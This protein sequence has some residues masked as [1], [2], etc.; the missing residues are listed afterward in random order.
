MAGNL[1][2]SKPPAFGK[3]SLRKPPGWQKKIPRTLIH[4]LRLLIL[5]TA[6]KSRKRSHLHSISC[7]LQLLF[8]NVL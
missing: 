3:S 2:P 6:E 7:P 8:S 1:P 4:E 5:P